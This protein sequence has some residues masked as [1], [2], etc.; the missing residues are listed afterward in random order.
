MLFQGVMDM[1]DFLSVDRMRQS[2]W[3]DIL[4]K[5]SEYPL[6]SLKTGAKV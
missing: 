3:K 2:R 5:L 6:V 4:E 1:S